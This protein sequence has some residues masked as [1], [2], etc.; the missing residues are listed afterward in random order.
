MHCHGLI[1]NEYVQGHIPKQLDPPSASKLYLLFQ[2]LGE[3]INKSASASQGLLRQTA[4][5]P[6]IVKR[7]SAPEKAKIL[8]ERVRT[9]L[10]YNFYY[11]VPN[12]IVLT[13]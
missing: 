10:H 6:N 12:A 9:K 4:K 3:I 5:I 2:Q 8:R 1:Q 11:C 13:P 7:I